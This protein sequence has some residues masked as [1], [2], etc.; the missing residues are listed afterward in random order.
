M[1][2]RRISPVELRVAGRRLEG[3]AVPYGARDRVG[4]VVESV[5]PSAFHPVP[6]SI[7]LNLQ[8]DGGMKIAVAALKDGED[9]LRASAEVPA[10]IAELVKRG[11]LRGLS[12]EMRV[13]DDDRTGGTRLIRRAELVGLAICDVPALSGAGIELRKRASAG[14][15]SAF[16]TGRQYLCECLGPD[17]GQVEYMPDAFTDV[18]AKIAAGKLDIIAHAGSLNPADVLASTAAGSLRLRKADDGGLDVE[19]SREAMQSP[20]GR[21]VTGSAAGAPII[22]PIV[23]QDESEFEDVDGVRRYSRVAVKSLLVK[24]MSGVEDSGWEPAEITEGRAA[25]DPIIKRGRRW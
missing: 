14:M 21:I 23:D 19:V 6:P 16:K 15:S 22:R 24:F 2:Y 1:I 18:V 3:V 12:V 20:A 9:A 5:R 8:H 11:A 17:C 13:L 10:G 25:D 7:G 4:G